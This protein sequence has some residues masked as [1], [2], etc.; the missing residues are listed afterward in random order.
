M[1][2]AERGRYKNGKAEQILEIRD[3]G[4]SNTITKVE[5]DNRLI[6]NMHTSARNP[7]RKTTNRGGAFNGQ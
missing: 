3:D 5:K 7:K 6:L 1:I 4:I 2:A